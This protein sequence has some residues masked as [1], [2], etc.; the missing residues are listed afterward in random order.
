MG[1]GAGDWGR[2][3]GGWGDEGWE[4]GGEF[5]LDEVLKY[6]VDL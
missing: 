5:R 4:D 2:E 6:C 1:L 3:M